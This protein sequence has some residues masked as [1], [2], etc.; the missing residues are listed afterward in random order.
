MGVAAFFMAMCNHDVEI[1]MMHGVACLPVR[2]NL[3]LNLPFEGDGGFEFE[4]S[5]G[6]CPFGGREDLWMRKFELHPAFWRVKRHSY[7][8]I[9]TK[10][11]EGDRKSAGA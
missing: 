6:K 2:L 7:A 10:K 4:K 11:H 5:N 8:K 1:R 3:D 9:H